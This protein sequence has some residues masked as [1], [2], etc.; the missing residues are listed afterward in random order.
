M[1]CCDEAWVVGIDRI[2]FIWII[3][4]GRLPPKHQQLLKQ[5]KKKQRRTVTRCIWHI[6]LLMIPVTSCIWHIIS[7]AIPITSCIWHIIHLTGDSSNKLYL[8]YHLT[9]DSSNKLY[10]A[11]HLTGD[12]CNCPT[13]SLSGENDSFHLKN[14]NTFDSN[15]Y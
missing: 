2:Q 3:E 15:K 1:F 5:N 4:C 10:L 7:L 12:S 11:Y 9:G 13:P 8:A 6:I 14:H